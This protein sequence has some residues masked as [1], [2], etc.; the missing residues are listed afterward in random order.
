MRVQDTEFDTDKVVDTP[1]L[2]AKDK[3]PF[4]KEEIEQH[5]NTR[6]LQ[7]SIYL[8]KSYDQGEE[9]KEESD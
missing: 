2:Y 9:S 7:D 6:K 5:F 4:S 8:A 1:E 3:S